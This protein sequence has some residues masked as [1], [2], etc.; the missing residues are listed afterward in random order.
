MVPRTCFATGNGYDWTGASAE[1]LKRRDADA[2]RALKAAINRGGGGLAQ[3]AAH[4]LQVAVDQ[5]DLAG[6]RNCL[7]RGADPNFRSAGQD[8][9]LVLASYLGRTE[10]V[11]ALLNHGARVD[12][13]CAKTKH[14]SLVY[15]AHAGHTET[16][17][18]LL[19]AGA[20]VLGCVWTNTGRTP[21]HAA[22]RQ[23]QPKC[24]Q[25]LID[26]GAPVSAI[27][28]GDNMPGMQ[29]LHDAAMA[30]DAEIVRMLLEAGADP[31][32]VLKLDAN[33]T[34]TP[35][36]IAVSKGHEECAK[37][38]HAHK[39]PSSSGMTPAEAAKLTMPQ[40]KAELT[41]RGLE[42]SG[43]KAV[44]LERLLAA[45]VE[46]AVAAAPA[47]SSGE[48]RARSASAEKWC[49]RCEKSKSTTEE[50]QYSSQAA[51]V[52]CCGFDYS[53]MCD[54]CAFDF[55]SFCEGCNTCE[56]T[57]CG[58]G[59]KGWNNMYGPSG[60]VGIS[61]AAC[62]PWNDQARGQGFRRFTVRPSGR[63]SDMI[64]GEGTEM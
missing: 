48:K 60:N 44:L 26:A 46:P 20:S 54:E 7:A 59:Q 47:A 34:I 36:D 6:V 23:G 11:R 56:C 21:L 17:K 9:A 37:L 30:G 25:Q 4:N 53:I 58:T 42:T 28:G 35:L 15:A 5:G 38:M 3:A 31:M 12:D 16:V 29:P 18:V 40:L 33:K 43:L 55:I 1:Q 64:V 8:P 62:K 39:S 50:F 52:A 19:D 57:D 27:Q 24:A 45:L 61:C 32:A 49:D 63:W 2:T 51:C 14:S 41:E 22:C 10:I 13:G